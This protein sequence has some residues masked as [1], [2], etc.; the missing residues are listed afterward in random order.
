VV[1]GIGTRRARLAAAGAAFF[2][3]A[4]CGIT[5]TPTSK[6]PKAGTTVCDKPEVASQRPTALPAGF[7]AVS[8]YR[9]SSRTSKDAKGNTWDVS[10]EE[11]ADSRLAQFVAELRKPSQSA[12]PD[13][14]R[15]CFMD[16]LAPPEI[17]HVVLADRSGRLVRPTYPAIDD[18]C[19]R[20]PT[21]RVNAAMRLLPWHIVGETR[22]SLIESAEATATGCGMGG[23]DMFLWEARG[24]QIS[25][26]AKR[27]VF[28]P[29][30]VRM[31][32]CLYADKPSADQYPEG[33]F[34]A[35][36]TVPA[37]DVAKLTALI[38]AA[39]AAQ[40][41]A[42]HHSRFAN[43]E[44]QPGNQLVYLELDGCHRLM[45]S[46]PHTLLSPAPAIIDLLTPR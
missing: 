23:K 1:R 29:A 21:A 28:S 17:A 39:P 13:P 27:P 12:S 34:S 26:G 31:K 7:I 20:F 41:C 25:S 6:T 43:I 33:T 5:A 38:E 44:V 8:A 3:A 4:A 24:G 35:G 11:R 36:G 46:D 30:P 45:T 14:N 15:A 2:L 42:L 9:C 22:L 19:H 37:G 10:V 32:F 40:P 18:G 16:N